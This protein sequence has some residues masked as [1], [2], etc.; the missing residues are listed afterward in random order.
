MTLT[1]LRQAHTELFHPNQDWFDG[2]VFMERDLPPHIAARWEL[3]AGVSNTGI[4]PEMILWYM[5]DVPP[6]V[7]LAHLYVQCPDDPIW[8]RY[9]W[10]SDEDS[11]GQR[12]FVGDNGYGLEIHRYLKLTDR[13]ACPTWEDV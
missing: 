10:T 9:L 11:L 7:V 2:E 1:E 3:P 5:E 13:F 8:R 12:V 6:A 4:P